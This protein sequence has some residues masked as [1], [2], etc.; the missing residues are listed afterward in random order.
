MTTTNKKNQSSL[1]P[2]PDK[3]PVSGYVRFISIAFEVLIINL[4]FIW[5][6]LWID[7]KFPTIAPTFIIMGVVFATAATI[8]YL[9]IRLNR[10]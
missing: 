1:K 10:K 9:L 3:S 2:S 8:Y 4:F 5:G 6:G 7:Q